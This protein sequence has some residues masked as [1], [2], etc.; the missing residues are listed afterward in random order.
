MAVYKAKSP[1]R[2]TI[3]AFNAE[4]FAWVRVNQKLI[5]KYEARP[6]PSQ[7]VK[8]CIKLPEVR[9]TNIKRVNTVK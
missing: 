3:N 1:K 8:N 2:F 7:P 9:S 4:A 5:S 6:T